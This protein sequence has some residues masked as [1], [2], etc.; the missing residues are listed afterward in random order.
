MFRQTYFPVDCAEN[1]PHLGRRKKTPISYGPVRK[2][3]A[4]PLAVTKIVFFSS[5][6]EKKMQNV[7]KWKNME[8]YFVTFLQGYPLKTNFSRY[9]HKILKL[10]FEPNFFS[11]IKTN[12]LNFSASFN[13]YNIY[14][15]IIYFR[16]K[17]TIISSDH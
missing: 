12:I 3:G 17:P 2:R 10:F 16:K 15:K 8:K 1:L 14:R 11:F 4:N 6:K 7:L 13:I 5:E 9:F